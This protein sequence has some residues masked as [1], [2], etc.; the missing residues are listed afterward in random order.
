LRISPLLGAAGLS[1]P[2][3]RQR[4]KK[5]RLFIGEAEREKLEEPINGEAEKSW[6]SP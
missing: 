5:E 6:K 2:C 3:R 4:R 1:I